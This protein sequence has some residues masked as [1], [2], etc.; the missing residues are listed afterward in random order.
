MLVQAATMQ[1]QDAYIHPALYRR[2]LEHAKEGP[3]EPPHQ[4]IG[5]ILKV[6]RE[7]LA[8]LIVALQ[9]CAERTSRNVVQK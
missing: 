5:R 1:Q 9:L 3:H 2:P 8:G 7:E 4:G 6:G